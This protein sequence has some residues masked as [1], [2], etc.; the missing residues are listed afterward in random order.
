MSLRKP[1]LVC[2]YY[3]ID[4]RLSIFTVTLP[5]FMLD[6]HQ[7]THEVGGSVHGFIQQSLLR[8]YRAGMIAAIYLS[9]PN[10]YVGNCAHVHAL[11]LPCF[12]KCTQRTGVDATSCQ[13]QMCM[14]VAILLRS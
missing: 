11:N 2:R 7:N 4:R 5:V 1:S 9:M 6:I 14:L 13:C 8:T 12:V 10:V 3:Y